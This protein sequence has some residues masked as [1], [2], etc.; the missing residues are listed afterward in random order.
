MGCEGV[1]GIWRLGKHSRPQSLA[2]G[3]CGSKRAVT[4]A[5]E[6][7]MAWGEG[8]EERSASGTGGASALGVAR[9]Q[10][11]GREAVAGRVCRT[12][13]WPAASGPRGLS[14]DVGGLGKGSLGE[15]WSSCLVPLHVQLGREWG[16]VR[17]RRQVGV[18]S[19]L[20]G[21]ADFTERRNYRGSYY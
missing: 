15:R 13:E 18:M 7:K 19:F 16:P 4:E 12:R 10:G 11:L 6:D 14:G 1:G 17:G 5:G 3:T 9:L 21:V 2:R 8:L 20:S